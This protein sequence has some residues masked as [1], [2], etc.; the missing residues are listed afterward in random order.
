MKKS[1]I[2]RTIFALLFLIGFGIYTYKMD[3]LRQ[4]SRD[5][6]SWGE[7]GGL[8]PEG[9]GEAIQVEASPAEPTVEPT[10]EPTE[11]PAPESDLPDIDVTSW[12]FVLVNAENKLGSDYAP[13]EVVEVSD[14]L[15]PQDS[16]IAEALTSFYEGAQAQGL[17]VYLSSG[18]RSYADQSYLYQ[19]KIDQGYSKEEAGRI[20]AEPG[21][22]EHQTGLCC[23]ITDVYRETKSWE[24]L[25]PTE[26]YQWLQAHCQ[27]YGFIVRY[28]KSKSGLT[29]EEAASSV[30]GIIYEPWH[31]RY[32]GV[33][34][35]TYI[36]E[37]DLCLEEFLALYE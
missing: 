15:C 3:S 35:A 13:P 1:R 16:R 29:T 4:H 31:F 12:E 6:E 24:A 20:V 30:T 34:A 27:E 33:E 22:S 32:V 36:M 2:A 23:D 5:V 18:Y 9:Y 7:A 37:N 26:T 10:A 19:R 28:P 11:S 25:E 21:T 8:H 17:P 14:S